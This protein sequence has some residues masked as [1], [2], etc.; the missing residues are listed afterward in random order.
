[1]NKM[2]LKH[3]I[4]EISGD[5]DTPVSLYAKLN[6]KNSY[7]LE[8]VTGGEQ[9]ARYS[10]IGFNPLL[11]FINQN[12]KNTI[13]SSDSKT[14]ENSNNPID[15]LK[16]L[17]SAIQV[18]DLKIEVPFLGGAVGYFSWESIKYIEKINAGKNQDEKF[19]LAHFMFPKNM[20]IFDH[21]M[22]KILIFVLE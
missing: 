2:I 5:L 22:Q 7:L 6:K 21:A 15:E 1:M 17:M 11:T 16:K 3:Y 19:P 8:S 12:N 10:F 13:F 4:K 20:V 14:E 18:D 9:V